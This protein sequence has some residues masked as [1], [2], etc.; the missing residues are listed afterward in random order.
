MTRFMRLVS[1]TCGLAICSPALADEQAWMGEILAGTQM[2]AASGGAERRDH[3]VAAAYA[4]RRVLED[5]PESSL[6]AQLRGPGVSVLGGS[7]LTH[8]GLQ[9]EM[10]A[11]CI[12]A[13]DALCL[14]D[15]AYVLGALVVAEDEAMIRDLRSQ[16]PDTS[17]VTSGVMYRF[18]ADAALIYARLGLAKRVQ[19]TVGHHVRHVGQVSLAERGIVL[20]EMVLALWLVGDSEAAPNLGPGLTADA[21]AAPDWERAMVQFYP[22]KAEEQLAVLELEAGLRELDEV[23]ESLPG[24]HNLL[25][26]ILRAY[27]AD[28]RSEWVELADQIFALCREEHQISL[29][30][31]ARFMVQISAESGGAQE[32]L[33]VIEAATSQGGN[34][35]IFEPV[36]I[37]ID[38][39]D[40]DAAAT[41]YEA[42]PPENVRPSMLG[43]IGSTGL[44]NYLARAEAAAM[45]MT[46]GR[47]QELGSIGHG[48]LVLGNEEGAAR[49]F[50]AISDPVQREIALRTSALAVP[51]DRAMMEGDLE[52]AVAAVS[53]LADDPL[54]ISYY[55]P[56]LARI[57]LE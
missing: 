14:G 43:L 6:A 41:L 17:L 40:G 53:A 33:D 30:N 15:W 56:R 12:A 16:H 2:A 18:H 47:D 45:A 48:Y 34:L 57:A 23:L 37:F 55:L 35:A 7:P 46:E 13:P 4:S 31:C 1:L 32:V 25:E 21:A 5:A 39:G 38:R 24:H 28:P 10:I 19:A 26:P 44:P 3:L 8:D 36:S 52:A 49:V 51:V 27:R 42:R 22:Q 29:R 54:W 50:G 20:P 11:A 9:Q